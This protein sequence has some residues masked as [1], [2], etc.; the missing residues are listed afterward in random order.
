MVSFDFGGVWGNE[1]QS[2]PRITSLVILKISKAVCEEIPDIQFSVYID[3][4]T[5]YILSNA[6]SMILYNKVAVNVGR[7]NLY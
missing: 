6:V 3:L 1:F 5:D 4:Y 7:L 2:S